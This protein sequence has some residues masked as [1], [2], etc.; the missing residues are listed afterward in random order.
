MENI[1][2][3][4]SGNIFPAS[5]WVGQTTQQCSLKE[6]TSGWILLWPNL[7]RR[8]HYFI[9]F[10]LVLNMPSIL[11]TYHIM[12]NSYLMRN[13]NLRTSTLSE[14]QP[15]R[16]ETFFLSL[17]PSPT[18]FMACLITIKLPVAGWA[19]TR[20]GGGARARCMADAGKTRMIRF[21]C[22]IKGPPK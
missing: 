10:N 22:K 6:G 17:T 8:Q 19:N 16:A 15:G 11:I 3:M 12:G 14:C 20:S 5:W 21:Q 2:G 1:Q 4:D 13:S 7:F 9:T 18:E